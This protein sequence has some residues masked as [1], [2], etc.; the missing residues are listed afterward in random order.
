VIS[1]LRDIEEYLRPYA[2]RV[3]LTHGRGVTTQRTLE[4]AAAVGSPQQRI[5][6][7]HVAGTSGKTS[8]SYFISSLISQAGKSVGL[9][10]SPHITSIA[11]RVMLNGE[12]LPEKQFVN[13]FNEYT[14]ILET[15]DIEPTYFEFMIVFALWVFD[16]EQVDYAVVETGLGGLHDSSNIC[17]RPDKLCVITDIGFDHMHIL[18]STLGEIAVQKVGIIAQDNF[19]VMYE[20]ASEIMEKV[21]EAV[22]R[23][24]ATLLLAP[25]QRDQQTYL[26]RNYSLASYTYEQLRNRDGLLSLTAEQHQLALRTNVPGRLE[27]IILG[28]TH[29]VLD[30]AHNEQKMSTLLESLKLL[31]YDTGRAVV[32]LAMKSDKQLYE[33]CGMIEQNFR[34]IVVTEFT[35]GQDMPAMAVRAKELAGYFVKSTTVEIESDLVV[36]LD[37]QTGG[38]ASF[39]LVTGSLYAVA[40]ARAILLGWGG[41]VQ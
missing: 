12:P 35:H 2:A 38:T 7:V 30:G 39:V 27:T 24:H 14:S 13:Y 21:K 19:V 17:R 9:T 41:R 10:V 16:R 3:P 23:N 34:R 37:G 18:G 36:A 11:E 1:T 31:N 4:L 8:T 20:Q 28:G 22:E 40:E 33:V 15:S 29:F 25:G 32:V 5:R 26:K 6:V